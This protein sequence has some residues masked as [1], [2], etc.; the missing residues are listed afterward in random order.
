MGEELAE[1]DL[2]GI[3]SVK[4]AHRGFPGILARAWCKGR[5][6]PGKGWEVMKQQNGIIEGWGGVLWE[7]E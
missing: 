5:V 4:N 2:F 3:F 1:W 6:V 7:Y